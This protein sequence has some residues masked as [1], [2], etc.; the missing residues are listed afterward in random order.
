MRWYR[1]NL[2]AY[3]FW[4]CVCAASWYQTHDWTLTV[5]ATCGWLQAALYHWY[6]NQIGIKTGYW[7]TLRE[8]G[9]L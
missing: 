5:I 9:E 2:A 1:T 8:R 6:A 7:K 3:L 4:A